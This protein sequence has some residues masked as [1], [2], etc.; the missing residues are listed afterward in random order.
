M[1][2]LTRRNFLKTSAAAAAVAS[3]TSPRVHAAGDETIR[4]ALVG[5]G[6]R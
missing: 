6:G 5:C 3:M 4:I 1:A 2:A